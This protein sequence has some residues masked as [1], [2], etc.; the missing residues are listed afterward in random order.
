MGD[1]LLKAE[2]SPENSSAVIQRDPQKILACTTPSSNSSFICCFL[3]KY[4]LTCEQCSKIVVS[5]IVWK[6]KM[7]VFTRPLGAIA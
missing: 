7:F 6:T 3:N 1:R 2:Q 5:I 4:I